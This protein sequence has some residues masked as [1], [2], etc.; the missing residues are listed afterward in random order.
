MKKLFILAVICMPLLFAGCEK[1]VIDT[2]I[3]IY[4]TVYDADTFSPIQDA[5]VYI[6]PNSKGG[7]RTGSDGTY[8]F[9]GLDGSVKQ[10][11]VVAKAS[12]YKLDKRYANTSNAER[13]IEVSFSLH[14]E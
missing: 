4:G 10:Y 6:Q 12:G 14:K 5:E 11:T 3:T 13:K 1:R 8:Q 2:S 7:T 9:D